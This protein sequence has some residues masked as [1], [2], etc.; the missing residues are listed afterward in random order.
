MARGVQRDDGAVAVGY[1]HN[2]AGQCDLVLMPGEPGAIARP[3]KNDLY[4]KIG[5]TLPGVDTARA[6]LIERGIA[7]SAPRQFRDIGYMCHL[8]DPDGHA[9]EFLQHTF[10]PEHAGMDRISGHPLRQ[11]PTLAHITLRT[12]DIAAC[13]AFYRDRLGMALTSVQPVAPAG[14]TLYFYA[15]TDERL[16]DPDPEAVANREWL[17]QRPYTQIEIQ[18]LH[19]PGAPASVTRP[20]TSSL[21]YDH[22]AI[23]SPHQPTARLAGPDGA[24]LQICGLEA[25]GGGR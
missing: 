2:G 1:G 6:A 25:S 3:T 5:L 9:I 11:E 17:W 24:A 21:G 19:G 14:F 8:S 7:V 12:A 18:H 23:S 10:G 4:W 15:F 16:P 22:I 20:D 13:H